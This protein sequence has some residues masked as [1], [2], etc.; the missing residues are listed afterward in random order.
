MVDIPGVCD[1]CSYF[2]RSGIGGSGNSI[3]HL[4]GNIVGPCPKCGSMGHIPDG[5]YRLTTDAIEILSATDKSIEELRLFANILRN[6]REER[7]DIQGLKEETEKNAPNLLSV[8]ELILPKNRNEKRENLFFSVQ[9]IIATIT[10][11]V[12]MQTQKND[13]D[14]AVNIEGDQIINQFYIE[15][16]QYNKLQLIKSEKIPRNSPCYCGSGLKFKK[17]HGL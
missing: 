9:M 7:I 17:C 1:S 2:F 8:L 11:L 14:P 4:E 5:V 3:L 15:E 13:P 6:F 16:E 12:S 10:L